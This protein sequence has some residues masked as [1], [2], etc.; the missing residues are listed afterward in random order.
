ML[1][2]IFGAGASHDV[3]PSAPPSTHPDLVGRVPLSTGLFGTQYLT[4]QHNWSDFRGILS[5]LRRASL[6]SVDPLG[7]PAVEDLLQ[8]YQNEADGRGDRDRRIQLAAVRFY[9]RDLA[10]GWS[11]RHTLEDNYVSL[12]DRINHRR[13]LT[14]AQVALVT[15]NYETLLESAL[16]IIEHRDPAERPTCDSQLSEY[17]AEDRPFIVLKPHGSWQWAREVTRHAITNAPIRPVDLIR[18]VDTLEFGERFFCVDRADTALVGE[19]E[20]TVVFPCLA[21]PLRSKEFSWPSSHSDALDRCIRQVTHLICVG[22]RAQ[23]AHFLSRWGAARKPL[24]GIQI[25][26]Q[27]DVG[28]TAVERRLQEAGIESLNVIKAHGGFT[29]YIKYLRQNP[30]DAFLSS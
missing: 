9:L 25:V 4:P 10:Q 3:D 17:V 23:E 11:S 16:A 8:I 29:D 15:F 2:V 6:A 21:L 28:A 14:D 13:W 12:L 1:M 7:P 5:E 19:S 30:L 24:R 26:T 18:N 20:Q 22:W 27:H